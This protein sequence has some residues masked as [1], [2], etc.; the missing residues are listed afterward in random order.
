MSKVKDQD[1]GWDAFVRDL[2][3][4]DDATLEVGV[5]DPRIASYAAINEFGAPRANI[6]ERPAF[7][8][9]FDANG[10]K[11]S[12][13][14]KVIAESASNGGN[15]RAE[16][17]TLG[18]IMQSDIRRSIEALKS[19]PNVPATVAKKKSAD[20]LIDTGALLRSVD[21]KVEGV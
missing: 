15:P 13:I 3:R 12:K 10:E 21:Y 19:P 4:I 20:P 6:P 9:A 2:G 16:L 1:L 11:Y 18:R 7:R 14:V 8:M 17:D 5:F